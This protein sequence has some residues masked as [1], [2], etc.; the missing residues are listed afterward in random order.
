MIRKQ[1]YITAEQDRALKVQSRALGVSE[2]ELVRR[3]LD[4]TLAGDGAT[5]APPV[6]GALAELLA[7]ARSIAETHRLPDGYRF[8]RDALYGE[9]GQ[10]G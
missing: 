6:H 10:R 7:H 4:H 5:G 3:A 8:D 1:L 9:R 2:A